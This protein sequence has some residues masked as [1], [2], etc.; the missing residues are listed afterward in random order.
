MA[1]DYGL[2]PSRKITVSPPGVE[3][4]SLQVSSWTSNKKKS[5]TA[6]KPGLLW[7]RDISK[8]Q[9]AHPFPSF[10]FSPNPENDLKSITKTNKLYNCN[11]NPVLHM[12]IQP[13]VL[14]LCAN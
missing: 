5:L 4:V 11:I 6:L 8:D 7:I 13:L 9:A 12:V 1:S 14:D 10:V 2:C 3:L